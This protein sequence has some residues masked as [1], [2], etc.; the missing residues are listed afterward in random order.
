MT[1]SNSAMAG[2]AVYSKNVLALYDVGVLGVSSLF[3]WRCPA[4]KLRKMFTD[5]LTKNHMDV[6]VGTGYF[7]DKCLSNT[8]RRVALLDL[9]SNSLEAAA[10]R[11]S[12]FSPEVYQENVLEALD[13]N[14]EK[15]DSISLNYLLHCLPGNMNEKAVVFENLRP[16]LNPNGIIF[17][18]TILG[19]G[20]GANFVARKVMSIYNRKGI[21][22]NENDDLESLSKGLN[23][24]FKEVDI[25]VVGCVAMF[26]A[27]I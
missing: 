19:T 27:K 16:Y 1:N 7:L 6:G 11:I 14:C 22:G 21:F 9:N 8:D 18:S 2:Q 23:E 3:F 10:S 12:R 20:V 26:V 13:F 24:N 15:F 25:R 17:G 5:N 4:K